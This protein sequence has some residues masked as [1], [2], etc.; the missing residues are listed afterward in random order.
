MNDLTTA[1]NAAG[2]TA[3]QQA[4]V[5]LMVSGGLSLAAAGAAAGYADRSATYKAWRLDHVQDEYRRAVLDAMREDVPLALEAR[6]ALLGAR[7]ELVRL[8][9]AQ[10]VLDRAGLTAPKAGT[11]TVG[12]VNVQINLGD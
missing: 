8:H 6:R 7:S 5:D 1:R 11:I 9:A 3:R 10:D 12:T 4:L 2:L